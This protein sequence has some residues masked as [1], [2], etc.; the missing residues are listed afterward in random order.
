MYNPKIKDFLVSTWN[1][2]N[3]FALPDGESDE[4]PDRRLCFCQIFQE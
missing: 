2:V 4:L 1:R 3:E